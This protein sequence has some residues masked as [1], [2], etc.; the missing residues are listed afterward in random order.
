MASW[1]LARNI[2]AA[3]YIEIPGAHFIF[4]EQSA[5]VNH[6]IGLGLAAAFFPDKAAFAAYPAPC[7]CEWCA[8]PAPAESVDGNKEQNSGTLASIYQMFRS[9]RE[10]IAA[11]CPALV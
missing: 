4:D 7:E 1:T 3:A 5:Q 11:Y 8:R 2:G 10:T 9:L 6:L